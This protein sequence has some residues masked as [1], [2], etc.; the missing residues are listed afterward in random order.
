M[1][2]QYENTVQINDASVEG[3]ILPSALFRYFQQAAILHSD[4]VGYTHEKFI[5]MERVWMLSKLGYRLLDD[6]SLNDRLKVQTW[7]LGMQRFRGFREF[8]V[9]RYNKPVCVASSVWLFLDTV[10]K[11]PSK[12]EPELPLAYELETPSEDV[13]ILSENKPELPEDGSP[14]CV[15]ST[16]FRD[17]DINSHLN[18]T[19]YSEYVMEACGNIL[20]K[21]VNFSEFSVEFSHEIPLGTKE[22]EIA[23]QKKDKGWI[24]SVKSGAR[25]NAAG[26]FILS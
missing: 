5:A 24:F 3:K 17:F 26:T 25:V 16:R 12:V 22:A 11:R 14:S 9:L 18:N 2:F 10:K 8:R 15:I 7:S 1:I 21:N 4:F 6:I 13:L 23:L 20:G 19:V